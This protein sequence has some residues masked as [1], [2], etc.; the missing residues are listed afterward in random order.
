MLSVKDPNAR[1][2]KRTMA[3]TPRESAAIDR[4]AQQ[5]GLRGLAPLRH[6]SVTL[7]L[8]LYHEQLFAPFTKE[9]QA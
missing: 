5:H 8:Q 2:V 1:T 7:L 4:Y 3:L 6:A 9:E